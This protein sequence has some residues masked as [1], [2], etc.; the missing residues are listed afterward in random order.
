MRLTL[1][2]TLIIVA[3]SFAQGQNNRQPETQ[4]GNAEQ[5]VRALRQ[6]LLDAGKRN[7]RPALE[8]MIADGFTFIHSTGNIDTKKVG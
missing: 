7:E 2:I 3:S 8:S 4:V 5:E 6:A 1:G